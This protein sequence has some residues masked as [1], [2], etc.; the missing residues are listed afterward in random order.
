[1]SRIGTLVQRATLAAAVTFFAVAAVV[2]SPN[3]P[4]RAEGGVPI[5][6]AAGTGWK[7]V[8]GYNTGTHNESDGQDP[9]A[10]DIVRT[11]ASTDWTPVLAPID[12]VIGWF[13]NNCLIIVDSRDF[14][15]LLCHLDPA[16]HLQRGLQ[17]SVNDQLGLVFPA[18]YDANGGLAHI[19]YAIHHYTGRGFLGRSVPF[20]GD[21]ALEGEDLPWSDDYNLHAGLEFVSS[22]TRGWTPPPNSEPESDPPAEEPEAPVAEPQPP[23]E[24][25]PARDAP[26]GG[27]R[28]VGVPTYTTVAE[29][30]AALDAPIVAFYLWHADIQHLERYH[31]NAA[32]ADYVGAR[33]LPAGAAVWAKVKDGAAWVPTTTAASAP[34]EI[35]LAPGSNLVSWQ[36]PTVATS[37]A[38]REIA[39]LSHAYRWDPFAET[40]LVW[41]PNTPLKSL[42]TLHPGDAVWLVVDTPSVWIQR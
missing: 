39:G 32:S 18:G 30:F 38:L 13:D 21:Y 20:A 37:E 8:A 12:G 9:H 29:Q 5:P 16:D 17:V 34:T 28:M 33:T 11:D 40:Y 19:H 41:A 7:I 14:G 22:N 24:V 10:I 35:A 26:V 25:M 4:V 42:S 23:T 15:H 2:V 3:K 36:G 27:W 31:P 1:M 6:A